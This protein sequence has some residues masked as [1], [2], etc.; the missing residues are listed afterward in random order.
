MKSDSKDPRLDLIQG[1]S[2]CAKTLY[3]TTGQPIPREW[4]DSLLNNT[5]NNQEPG[6]G[7]KMLKKLA[8]VLINTLAL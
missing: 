8:R 4:V 3:Q 2:E 6:I 5:N 1:V 7:S